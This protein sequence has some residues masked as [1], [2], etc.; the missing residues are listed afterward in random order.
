ML[1]LKHTLPSGQTFGLLLP[2]HRGFLLSTEHLA[3]FYCCLSVLMKGSTAAEWYGFR[4]AVHSVQLPVN[5]LLHSNLKTFIY[6]DAFSFVEMRLEGDVQKPLSLL[7][8]LW[9]DLSHQLFIINT[10]N[11]VLEADTL[12][13][14]YCQHRA[15][16]WAVSVLWS[17]RI[18]ATTLRF[19]SYRTFAYMSWGQMSPTMYSLI[20]PPQKSHIFPYLTFIL[21]PNPLTSSL[22]T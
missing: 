7:I 16:Q 22:I 12:I 14:I 10:S 5:L 1:G 18:D 21:N 17:R 8:R 13:D 6:T 11:D 9:I 15:Q 20:H 4:F 2:H 3:S 19:Y